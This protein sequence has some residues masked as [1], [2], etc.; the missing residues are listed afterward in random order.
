MFTQ[1]FEDRISDVVKEAVA[2]AATPR[3]T[4]RWLD[5]EHAGEYMNSTGEAV[6]AYV[7]QGYF[8]VV[9]KNGKRWIDR[10]DIDLFMKNHK[11]YN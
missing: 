1:E 6:R 2:K 5:Y 4:P 10:E 11:Q 7:R 8:P 3:I 9:V